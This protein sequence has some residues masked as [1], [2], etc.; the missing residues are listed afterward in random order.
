MLRVIKMLKENSPLTIKSTF[1]GAHAIPVEFKKQKEE[2]IDLIINKML[3][4]IAEEKREQTQRD[5]CG[6]RGD[7]ESIAGRVKAAFP[8]EPVPSEEALFKDHCDECI[9]VSNA[10]GRRPWT[11]VPLC[12]IVGKE[13]A[14]LT[15]TAWRYFLPAMISWCVRDPEALDTLP[16]FLV[17]QLEPPE[18]S[19]TDP[20]KTRTAGRM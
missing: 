13:T 20:S 16:E 8:D 17:Y 10:F 7:P 18:P 1:L 3:P 2:Y 19:K 15:A 12:D 4:Q 11:A 5:R 14:L 6:I 9:D